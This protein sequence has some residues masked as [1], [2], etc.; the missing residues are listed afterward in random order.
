MILRFFPLIMTL[1][2]LTGCFSVDGWKDPFGAY[3]ARVTIEERRAA[4]REAVARY[5]RD[6]RIAEAENAAWAKVSAAWAWAWT[7]PLLAVIAGASVIVVVYIRWNGRVTIARMRY[8]Y[9]PKPPDLPRVLPK[10]PSERPTLAELQKLA[11]N[12]NQHVEIS[13]G[14]A[15]LIDNETGEVIKR[16]RL[17]EG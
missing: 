10:A 13:G 4:S 7:L 8:G 15:L 2:L 1:L 11:A 3:A 12:R 17:L 14:V 5:S 16:R 9:L 6:A